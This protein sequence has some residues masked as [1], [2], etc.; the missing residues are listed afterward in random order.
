[1]HDVD[2]GAQVPGLGWAIGHTDLSAEPFDPEPVMANTPK[3]TP[4]GRD[5]RTGEF[6]TVEWAKK[7]PDK[8]IV[9][10]VPT[11]GNGD[12]SPSKKK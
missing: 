9:E 7:H 10:R 1:M 12:T 8:G 6:K 3:T 11:P 5:A 4:R 2:T